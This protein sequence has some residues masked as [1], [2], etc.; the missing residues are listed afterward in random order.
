MRLILALTAVLL[1]LFAGAGEAQPAPGVHRLGFLGQTS[2]S[3]QA[4]QMA[5]LRKG[6]RDSGYQ[7]G[8]NV[9]IE[10]RWAEGRL[11]RL[12]ELASE[13]ARLK[14]DVIVTHGT[15][16]T[17]AA[18]QATRTIPIVMAANSDPVRAG[19]VASL[20]RPGGNVTGLSMQDTEMTLKRLEFLKQ[21]APSVSRIVSLRARGVPGS[22]EEIIAAARALGLEARILTVD[23]P[24]D[25]ARELLLIAKQ[26][27]Q[28]IVLQNSSVLRAYGSTI[29]ALAIKHR[30][31][32]IAAPSFIDG[33]MLL[34]YGPNLEDMYRRAAGYVDRILKGARPGDLPIEQPVKFELL[35]NLKT[36]KALGLTIPPAVVGRADRVIE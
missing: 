29:A 25:L 1:A 16:G 14:V 9:V 12:P 8:A 11:S 36:A 10:Y 21:A 2:E 22:G 15:A 20:S 24:E 18:K 28:A 32:T 7:E 33:G 31:P 35:V 19:L 6:L 27:E 3:A 30:L 4:P 23:G 34:G 5:A 13:L 26:G 17:R